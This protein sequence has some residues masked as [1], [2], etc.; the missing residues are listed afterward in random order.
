RF[1]GVRRR[2]SYYAARYSGR[3]RVT[4]IAV[5]I[6]FVILLWSVVFGYQRRARGKL[7][8][9]VVEVSQE[10]DN[11]LQEAQDLFG[12]NTPKAL[13][14]LQEVKGEVTELEK[15]VGEEKI[16][17]FEELK[18]RVAQAE[19]TIKKEKEV[20]AEEFFNLN[21]IKKGAVA[22]SL[23][24]ER[25]LLALLNSTD[26]QI[27]TLSLSK[28]STNT[29]KG[30]SIKTAEY[31]ALSS[32][33]A[34]Y[35][36]SR[37]GVYSIVKGK[38][39]LQVKEDKWGKVKGFWMFNGNMY[40]FDTGEDEIYRYLVA[41]KGYG[42]K[43]SY[44]AKG[45]AVDLEDARD[46]AIDGSIYILFPRSLMRFTSGLR[47]GFTLG[48]PDKDVDFEQLYTDRNLDRLYLL[49]EDSG[50]V[51][52]FSKGG[53][54]IKQLSASVFSKADDF[55]VSEDEGGIFVLVKD[56]I[57]KIKLE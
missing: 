5:A 22:K 23:F 8:V 34:F 35:I 36:R 47:D 33:E 20:S 54:Y 44:F 56:I 29:I 39:K 9:Q 55:V 28:K 48:V 49:D 16:K 17:E 24:L 2:L 14:L 45:Q 10:V 43:S 32:D 42:G 13:A 57:Y 31:V 38:A 46:F 12:I 41:E 51:F 11:K 1:E 30:T 37:K 26:G 19:S 7:V 6:L 40:V 3:R 52:I 4:F 27:Y 15:S 53:E 50:R 21:L 18:K 25:D